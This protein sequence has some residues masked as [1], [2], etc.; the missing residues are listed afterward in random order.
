LKELAFKKLT[1][2]E[3]FFSV[4]ISF[5]LGGVIGLYNKTL[6]ILVFLIFFFIFTKALIMFDFYEQDKKNW[7]V[8][9]LK[10]SF[11]PF[12]LIYFP[13]LTGVAILATLFTNTTIFSDLNTFKIKSI[14]AFIWVIVRGL[15]LYLIIGFIYCFN[16][17]ILVPSTIEIKETV[18]EDD[19]SEEA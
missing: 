14:D 6:G 3:L 7:K 8:W 4:F 19:F 13:I 18:E 16:R 2:I 5:I 15:A 9:K 12:T 11:I 10:H 17:Y 1:K